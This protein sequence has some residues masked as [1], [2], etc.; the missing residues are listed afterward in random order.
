[1]TTVWFVLVALMITTYVVLDGFDLGVGA[2]HRL[3]GRTD[4]ERVQAAEAIGPVWNGNEVWLIAG[5][6]SL[7]LAFPRAYAAAFSGLYFG[8][9]IVLWL[10]VGRG[11]GLELR[12]QIDHP[13]W[14]IACDTVFW[15][16]S[17]AL[18]LVFG[19]ALGNVVRGVPLGPDGY[20]HLPLFSILN[21]YALLVGVFGL[22]ALAAHGA[23]FLAWRTDGGLGERARR[24]AR[25]LWWAELALLAGVTF[26]TDAVRP[27]LFSALADHPWRL[28]FPALA[29]AGLAAMRVVREARRVFLASAAFLAGLLATAAA[30]LYPSILPARQH[31]PFGLTIDNAASG[32]HALSVALWWWVP[33]VLLAGGY[34]LFI[35]RAFLRR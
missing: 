19:V 28:V 23:A 6:G 18:A 3:I 32:E 1:M 24:W 12:R 17:A 30:G 11:L 5:G 25:A 8:L 15:L 7:F 31:R 27:Q 22:V 34:F 21:W 4:A 29:L 9:M 2:L 33:G 20:F 35:Y 10:L 16:S 14:H 13:L 26:A